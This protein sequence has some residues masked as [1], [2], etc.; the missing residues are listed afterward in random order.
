MAEHDWSNIN[1]K[2]IRGKA[3]AEAAD[4]EAAALA[5]PA[6]AAAVPEAVERDSLI[7]VAR[8]AL[9]AYENRFESVYGRYNGPI[10]DEMK[11]LK[12]AIDRAALSQGDVSGEG[13]GA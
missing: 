12:A 8:T 6:Q 1:A 2:H 13:E 9:E 5:A 3:Q 11:A 10:D 4:R 7:D